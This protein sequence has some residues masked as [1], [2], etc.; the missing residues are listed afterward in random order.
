MWKSEQINLQ[1]T[2]NKN[3]P[4]CCDAW[5][6]TKHEFACWM[7]DNPGQRKIKSEGK[8]GGHK[9]IQLTI[10]FNKHETNLDNQSNIH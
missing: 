6:N 1:T 4:C 5:T 7:C 10:Q 3:Y 9:P 2:K 8:K